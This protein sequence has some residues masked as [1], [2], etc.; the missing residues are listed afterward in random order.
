MNKA[1]GVIAKQCESLADYYGEIVGHTFFAQYYPHVPTIRARYERK[2]QIHYDNPAK[3]SHRLLADVLNANEYHK[4]DLAE[5]FRHLAYSHGRNVTLRNSSGGTAKFYLNQRRKLQ[6]EHVRSLFRHFASRHETITVNGIEVPVNPHMIANVHY[7]TATLSIAPC[8]PSHG[9]LHER[10]MYSSGHMVHFEHAGWNALATE[11]ATFIWHTLFAGNHYGPRYARWATEADR[12]AERYARQ[13]TIIY[14]KG[15]LTITISKS[16]KDLLGDYFR[17]YLR[18][19]GLSADL[20]GQISHAIAF[21]LLTEYDLQSMRPSD[22]LALFSLA[23]YFTHN[24]TQLE[25]NLYQLLNP[26]KKPAKKRSST[27]RSY[28]K[29]FTALKHFF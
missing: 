27:E 21:R 13:K 25:E 1:D 12:H 3:G 18:K 4:R 28:R 5:A 14:E 17:Y 23:N 11:A 19:V 15:N 10:T 2:R 6:D 9:N 29:Y 26:A 20:Q 24:P 8:V 7:N 22:R 16:R